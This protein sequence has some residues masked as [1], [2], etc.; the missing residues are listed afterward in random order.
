MK[1]PIRFVIAVAA[2]LSTVLVGFSLAQADAGERTQATFARRTRPVIFVHG[3][4][5]SG[6]QFETQAMRFESNGYAPALIAMHE[7]DSL[8]T[9]ETREAVFTR[10]DQRIA[11]LLRLSHADKVD[12]L[13]HSLGTALMQQYLNSSAQRAATVAHYVNL[14]GSPAASPPGGVPTLAIW[15]SGSPSRK[16]TG[17]AN[18]YFTQQSHVQVVS[19]PETFEQIYSF[20][21]GKEPATTKVQADGGDRF[22]LSG[23]AQLF[24]QNSGITNGTLQIFEV[25]GAT[26]QRLDNTPEATFPLQGNGDWGPFTA[27]AGANYEFAVARPDAPTT[28]HIYYEPFVRADSWI[29]LLLS[30]PTGGIGDLVQRSPNSAALT[31]VRYKEQWGDQGANSDVLEVNGVNILT[32]ANSARAKL[33]NAVFAFDAGT[34][35]VTNLNTPIP[36]IS[37]LPFLTGA[38]IFVKAATPP[39]DT[40]SIASTPRLGGGRVHVVN[41]PNWAS[42]T[43]TVTV[44]L[45][46]Y[47][48][49]P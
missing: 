1:R 41:V 44:Q 47:L 40:I 21:T 19:S 32:P 23:R 45:N 15:G 30:P 2:L 29:R 5:G 12:L 27:R 14:D 7:Y 35:G 6:A 38:D 10:L 9:T 20:F 26:G 8:F 48:E 4:F 28:Q 16:I 43:D 13:G 49:T 37:G 36:G 42:S 39:N 33:V 46:D 34:D 18:I 17:A 25:N 31:I 11:D 3:F 24:P 22:K